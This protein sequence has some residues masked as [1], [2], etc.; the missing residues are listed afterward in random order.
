MES[1]EGT[2][3]LAIPGMEL[4]EVIGRG[5]SSVVYRAVQTRFDRLVAVKVLHLPG[6]SDLVAKLFLNECRTIGHLSPHPNVVS[7]FDAG[8]VGSPD[9][10]TSHPYLVMEYLPG[11]TLADRVG[12]EGPLP[13]EEVLRIGV[14]L[15]GGLHTVH[16]HDIVHGDIKP[17]NV[18]RSRTG[19]AALADFGIARLASA[20]GATTRARS[21]RR[22]TRRPS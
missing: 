2:E 15:A 14:Q 20:A 7:V 3:G 21:S 6:Q 5:A 11:G 16:L 1:Q 12:A 4:G 19:E 22:C 10:A 9:G 18:L 8:F 13:V 17:Q